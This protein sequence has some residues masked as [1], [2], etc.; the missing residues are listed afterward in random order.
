MGIF[1]TTSSSLIATLL[2]LTFLILHAPMH[3]SL[4]IPRLKQSGSCMI[5]GVCNNCLDA[6]VLALPFFG[7]YV[8]AQT[9]LAAAH[10]S[11][12]SN[13]LGVCIFLSLPLLL[14]PCF[15]PQVCSESGRTMGI[16][17]PAFALVEGCSGL[18]FTFCSLP[19][20]TGGT[21][22]CRVFFLP[23]LFFLLRNT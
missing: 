15:F 5:S 4:A 12:L 1:F 23:P 14:S 8:T 9:L 19:E 20:S 18:D 10:F 6:K 21:G 16:A 3:S 7:E 17:S 13:S 11:L 2:G 22:K